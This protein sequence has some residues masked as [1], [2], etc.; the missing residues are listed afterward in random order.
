VKR[1]TV[2]AAALFLAL[3]ACS[4]GSGSDPTQ[5]P[6]DGPSAEGSGGDV[7]DPQPPGHAAVSVD[8]LDFELDQP[9]AVACSIGDDSITFSF[10][11][12]DN[13]VTL[14]GG[15]NLYDTGWIGSI[16]LWVSNPEGG[17]GPVV[18]SPKL[19]DNGD[20]IA[21]DGASMSYSGPMR[22]QPPNDGT[23]PPPVDVGDGTI[24]VTCP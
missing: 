24:S 21:I 13:E 16:D 3:S 20:R 15:A 19:A 10:R 5:T 2:L 17:A 18:Y 23:N 4:G 6:P 8:G 22:M 9:G 1:Y 7:V 12:G 11:I 14:G